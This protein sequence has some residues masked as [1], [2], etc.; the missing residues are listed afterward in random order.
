M[1]FF[2]KCDDLKETSGLSSHITHEFLV[3]LRQLKVR[4]YMKHPIT[5]YSPSNVCHTHVHSF[6]V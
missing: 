1:F 5:C 2:Y 3:I 4:S 6:N